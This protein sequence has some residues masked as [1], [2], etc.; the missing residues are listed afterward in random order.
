MDDFHSRVIEESVI[1]V[2][3]TNLRSSKENNSV[4]ALI[5]ICFFIE[6]EVWNWE[7]KNDTQSA[8]IQVSLSTP[9]HHPAMC[10]QVRLEKWNAWERAGSGTCLSEVSSLSKRPADCSA[11][12]KIVTYTGQKTFGHISKAKKY[13]NITAL[14]KTYQ[15]KTTLSS[16]KGHLCEYTSTKNNLQTSSKSKIVKSETKVSSKKSCL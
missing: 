4:F 11:I 16:W 5:V 12:N 2:H 9:F 7:A 15:R 1:K 13:L 6:N 10:F 14:H 3:R 8:L